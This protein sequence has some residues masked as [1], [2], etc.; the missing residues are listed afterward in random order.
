M[1]SCLTDN[2]HFNNPPASI[3][4]SFCS[5]PPKKKH[6]QNALPTEISPSR[7]KASHPFHSSIQAMHQ[8]KLRT[9]PTEAHMSAIFKFKIQC[10]HKFQ[11]MLRYCTDPIKRTPTQAKYMINYCPRLCHC[12][13]EQF[14]DIMSALKRKNHEETQHS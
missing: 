8:I 4:S 1:L 3:D 11:P 10:N 12:R 13:P 5:P 2:L 7:G 6:V 14:Y 9:P